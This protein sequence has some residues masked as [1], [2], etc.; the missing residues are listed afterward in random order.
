MRAATQSVLSNATA[1][2]MP[3]AAEKTL[4]EYKGPGKR[5]IKCTR[6]TKD[7]LYFDKRKKETICH[8]KDMP[9]V[10]EK[11]DAWYE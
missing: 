5:L 10:K 7:H 6:F 1:V 3:S 9:G 4:T 8:N 11:A 2:D